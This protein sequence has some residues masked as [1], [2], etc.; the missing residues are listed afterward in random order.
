MTAP[1]P[2]T[3]PWLALWLPLLA[4]A[5]GLPPAPHAE[6]HD[7]TPQPGFFTEPS[8]AIN[9]RDPRQVVAAFQDNAHIS[10]STDS[11]AHW[12]AAT[13]IEPANYR[14]SGDVSVTFD[15]RGRAVVC[16]MAF[17]KLG[18]FNYWAHGATRNGLF[19]RRSLDGG[20]TWEA[21][22]NPIIEH[23]SEPG[24]PWEDKPYIVADDTNGPYGGNLYV[25]WTRWTLTDSQIRLS[26]STDGGLTWSAPVEIDAKRGLPRDDNGALEGFAGAVGGDGTLY[27]VWSANAT[28]QF[29]LSRD[30]GRTF[31]PPRDILQ[32][33]PTM[34]QLQAFSRANGFPQIAVDRRAGKR[35]WLYVTWSD[36]RNGGVDVFCA[37]SS[38]DGR[39]WLQP[40]RVN[41]DPLH[42]GA[43][44]F[45]QWL[46]ADPVTGDVDVLFYDRRA[47]PQ[48]RAQTVTLARS[49][50]G[51][52]TFADYAWTAAAFQTNNS[53][54]M[55]DYSGI[56]A[57]DGRVY[58]VWT[59]K[60]DSQTR[61]TVVRVG[62]A[63]FRASTAGATAAPLE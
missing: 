51:G 45:F 53:V 30:G 9:P 11:G 46:A 23:P 19:V 10:F 63:D 24:I 52:R 62:V 25:G 43:D 34:F 35:G 15:N 49:T 60:P 22:H 57:Y 37:A 2:R 48:N 5:Q 13:G 36:Y 31:A 18:R 7:L 29:T 1:S 26:R 33:G 39:T 27:A 47:D 32:T 55:G 16:Y 61:G 40:V 20:A 4:G 3:V 14:T 42:N 56:A 12:Q 6:V 38:D 58:G 8:I 41:S 59:E 28:L 54:F 44:H 17:D 50:D 21:N